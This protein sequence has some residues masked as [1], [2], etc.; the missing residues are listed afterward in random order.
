MCFNY[1]FRNFRYIQMS[2]PVSNNIMLVGCIFCLSS[3][4]LFGLDGKK[5]PEYSFTLMCHARA[6]VLSFGF[7]LAFGAMFTKIW[8]SYR[9]STQMEQSAKH[10][11]IKDIQVYLMIT[12]FCLIDAIILL[13]WYVQSPMT[14]RVERF[15]HISSDIADEDIEI[16]PQL[17]HC[18]ANL[19]WYGIVY[20]YK[21]LILIFGLFLSYETRSIKVKQMNDSRLV[22]MSIYNVVVRTSVTNRRRILC[23]ITGPVSLV[24]SNQTD[25]HFAF[26]AFTIIFCC[27]ISM[28][29]IFTPKVVELVRKRSAHLAFGGSHMNGTFHDTLTSQEQEERFQRLTLESEELSSKITEKD[30]QIEEIKREIEK[31]SKERRN[32]ENLQKRKAVRIQEPEEPKH[33]DVIHI[34]AVSDSGYVSNRNSRPSDFEFSESYL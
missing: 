7:S 24:I 17:E 8:F 15:D 20:C 19:I 27:F 31:L 4:V 3:I 13:F 12:S 10:R 33:I 1:K 21:G 26:I 34:D 5:V 14:R 6:F 11:K 30:A 32:K 25:A 16:E 18:D 29:L 23:M 28:A 22:G 9:L 2:H